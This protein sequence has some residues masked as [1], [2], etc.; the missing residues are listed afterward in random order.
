MLLETQVLTV[1]PGSTP[2]AVA[3]V[4][5]NAILRAE[6]KHLL[7]AARVTCP[8]HSAGKKWILDTYRECL[9]AAKGEV[10]AVGTR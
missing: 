4:L 6:D 3:L 9:A 2:E 8:E 10:A 7:P 1:P 5:L